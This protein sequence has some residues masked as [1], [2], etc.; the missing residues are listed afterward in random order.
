MRYVRK[1]LIVG[2]VL[3]PLWC[4]AVAPY[5]PQIADPLLEPW[6][7]R[8]VDALKGQDILCMDQAPDGTYWFGCYGGIIR[9]SGMDAERIDFDEELVSRIS[10]EVPRPRVPAVLCLDNDRLLVVVGRSL[11]VWSRGQCEIVVQEIKRSGAEILLKQASDGNIWLMTILGL[12]RISEDLSSSELLIKSTWRGMPLFSFCLTDAGGAWVVQKSPLQGVDLIHIPVVAGRVPPQ[13]EWESSPVPVRTPGADVS[14]A[15][16]ADGR[17]W[18]ADDHPENGIVGFDPQNRNWDSIGPDSMKQVYSSMT[19]TRDGT[20]W[21]CGLGLLCAIRPP[22]G[23]LYPPS[24]LGLPSNPL[25][26]FE[27]DDD[28]WWLLGRIGR[29]FLMDRGHRHWMTYQGLHFQCE[30]PD[31]RQWFISSDFRVVSHDPQTGEWVSYGTEDAVIA[32]PRLLI[33]S[34]DGLIWAPGQ[35][36]ERAAI[37]IFDGSRWVLHRYPKFAADLCWKTACEAADGTLWFMASGY[38]LLDLPY[39]GGAL[40]YEVVEGREPRLLKRH[41]APW[42]PYTGIGI[43]Q[44]ADNTLWF[45]AVAVRRLE[46]GAA[47]FL[48]VWSVPRTATHDL[49]VDMQ[50]ELWLAKIGAGLFRNHNHGWIHYTHVDGLAGDHVGDILALADGTLLAASDRGISRFDGR[51]WMTWA[52]SADFAMTHFSGSMRQSRDGAIWLNFD[53]QDP[54][55]P[56]VIL[57][58]E[59]RF[60]TVRYISDRQPPQTR[61][62]EYAEL[63]S[64]LGDTYI[65]WSGQDPFENSPR[66]VLQYSW[67]FSGDEWSP[68]SSESGRTFNN[69]AGGKY[70][71]AVRAR[72]RDL[73]IDPVPAMIRFTVMP[74]VW[75]RPWFVSMVLSFVALIVLLV[76]VMIRIRERNLTERQAARERLLTERQAEEQKRQAERE[77]HLVEMDQLKTG[78]FTNI[79]HELRTP[80]TVIL[81]PLQQMLTAHTYQKNNV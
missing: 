39:S 58:L 3:L 76:W 46:P 62:E 79:S 7:W 80:L 26:L 47:K 67:R 33:C 19:T 77:Q 69:L 74:H 42:L 43:V 16:G 54:R 40:Q 14:I 21:A 72:D 45:G 35:H 53:R 65:S 10:H 66:D 9:Y 36:D 63:V 31:G 12:W 59:E 2:L 56:Q 51:D 13:Q 38:V 64:S 27:A 48:T 52:F 29:V 41:A 25:R 71:F 49:A 20:T 57:N 60:C 70:E 24:K 75:Q 81:G 11:I 23:V 68:F 28:T 55:S 30:S 5:T 32:K 34:K 61:I 37:S 73:N 50:G 6:R 44:T 8:E 22:G 1:L 17:V 78:F 15:V 4:A 18:Y